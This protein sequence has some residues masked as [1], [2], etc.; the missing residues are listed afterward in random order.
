MSPHGPEIFMKHLFLQWLEALSVN[1]YQLSP[2]TMSRSELSRTMGSPHPKTALGEMEKHDLLASV[3]FH[4]LSA[5]FWWKCFSNQLLR[6]PSPIFFPPQEILNLRSLSSKQVNLYIRWGGYAVAIL[7][8]D[9]FEQVEDTD[10][11]SPCWFLCGIIYNP[12][13]LVR[14]YIL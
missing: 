14:P 4:V 13:Q 9:R 10:L 7:R 6:L 2:F 3:D 8:N 11:L 5:D 12:C 1:R